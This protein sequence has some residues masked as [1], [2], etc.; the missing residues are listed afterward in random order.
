MVLREVVSAR[1][2]RMITVS[3]AI[4]TSRRRYAWRIIMIPRLVTAGRRFI[5]PI[6][7]GPSNTTG[8]RGN[9]SFSPK[10]K[11]TKLTRKFFKE[12]CDSTLESQQ[13]YMRS[14]LKHPALRNIIAAIA[15][16][17][18]EELMEQMR[19]DMDRKKY[20]RIEQG[21][22]AE[23]AEEPRLP[24]LCSFIHRVSENSN[25]T[26]VPDSA[27]NFH[28]PDFARNFQ[29]PDFARV[30]EHADFARD[31]LRPRLCAIAER[32]DFPQYVT[33]TSRDDILSTSQ[34]IPSSTSVWSQSSPRRSPVKAE[35]LPL[36]HST[37]LLSKVWVPH[38]DPFSILAGV[39]AAADE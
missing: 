13:H 20:R 15:R 4:H 3:A 19:A 29:A 34:S 8:G 35:Y 17:A 24:K 21:D 37:N 36:P 9:N 31:F 6:G 22:E 27:R 26:I 28:S 2:W 7:S 38:Q 30:S 12:N 11:T 10:E 5:C 32:P 33:E 16:E 18:M 39:W 1:V 23:N 14:L 25:S